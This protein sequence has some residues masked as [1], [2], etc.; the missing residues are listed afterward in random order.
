MLSRNAKLKR[1][2]SAGMTSVWTRTAEGLLL[3][4]KALPLDAYRIVSLFQFIVRGL[5]WHHWQTLIPKGYL[6]EVLTL[7]ERGS[8]LFTDYLLRLSP[9]F[10][11]DVVLSDRVFQYTCTRN[12]QDSAFSAWHMQFYGVPAM[13]GSHPSGTMDAVHV[14]A[15]TGPQEVIRPAIDKFLKS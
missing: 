6:V 3:S 11:E 2:L 12:D 10:R 7:S 1:E 14:C 15:L 5:A 9:Q 8:T 4:S 13:A